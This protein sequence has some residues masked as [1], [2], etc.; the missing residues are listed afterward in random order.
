MSNVS[1]RMRGSSASARQAAS[2]VQ[3]SAAASD[4][5]ASSLRPR[6]ARPL[7]RSA[8][9]LLNASSAGNTP[10]SSI[11]SRFRQARVH[12]CRSECS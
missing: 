11:C 4:A 2:R 12:V 3:P 6:S 10:A 1:S 9:Q 7:A 5:S 8:S